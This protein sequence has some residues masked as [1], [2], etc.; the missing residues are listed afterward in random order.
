MPRDN[1]N[2]PVVEELAR[3]VAF[4]CSNPDCRNQTVGPKTGP[5]GF[6]TTGE[7]AH[8]TAA[9]PGGPRYDVALTSAERSAFKNGIWLCRNC[10]ALIDR[11]VAGYPVEKLTQWK[12]TAEARA[13]L[14]INKPPTVDD[15]VMHPRSGAVLSARDALLRVGTTMTAIAR[16]LEELDPRFRVTILHGGSISS[17]MFE[18]AGE[19]VNVSMSLR[20]EVNTRELM[21]R[22]L[23]YGEPITLDGKDIAFHGTP[24]LESLNGETRHVSISNP[25]DRHAVMRLSVA[26]KRKSELEFLDQSSATL[27]SG[28]KGFSCEAQLFGGHLALS[29]SSDG[30]R[31]HVQ[32]TPNYERWIG[33]GIKALP[34]F[35]QL[36]KLHDAARQ[37]REIDIVV[38]VEGQRLAAGRGKLPRDSFGYGLLDFIEEMRLILHRSSIDIVLPTKPDITADDI[39]RVHGL[40]TLRHTSPGSTMTATVDPQTEHEVESL[41]KSIAVGRPT[42]MRLT[43]LLDVHAFGGLLSEKQIAVEISDVVMTARRRNIKVGQSL[44]VKFKAT[45]GSKVSYFV[46]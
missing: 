22:F 15:V 33:R 41:Q 4:A 31:F 25:S 37:G 13:L 36:W 10:A 35:D 12:Q 21:K 34:Y 42:A 18:P 2:K 38:E 28:S 9:A 16:S 7:A 40:A 45:R 44:P 39:D 1:F 32:A 43:Q 24:L 11:D 20:D 30:Q 17:F 27:S 6:V 26:S 14:G 5:E 46:F 23:E 8:I 3:R 19:P 29:V